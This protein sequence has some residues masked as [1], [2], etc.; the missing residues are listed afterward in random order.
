MA[1]CICV[2]TLGNEVQT[3]CVP[4]TMLGEDLVELIM[5]QHHREG[6]VG[7]L[8]FNLQIIHSRMTLAE[9]D[10]FNG[11]QVRLVWEPLD[12]CLAAGIAIR[13]QTCETI[14]DKELCVYN[15]ITVVP[16]LGWVGLVWVGLG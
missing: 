3:I 11:A 5:A 13:R 8:W 16:G 9:H 10:M 12:V 1:L 15:S 7:S 14:S 4:K 6:C 2:T